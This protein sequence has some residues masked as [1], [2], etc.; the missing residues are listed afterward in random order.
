MPKVIGMEVAENSIPSKN[1]QP[2]KGPD[3]QTTHKTRPRGNQLRRPE[4]PPKGERKDRNQT[5]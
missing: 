4:T 2:V 3:K 1:L 5:S